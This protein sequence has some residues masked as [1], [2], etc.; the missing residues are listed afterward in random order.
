MARTD[1]QGHNDNPDY[2]EMFI[3]KACE[4]AVGM[5]CRALDFGCGT[6]RNVVNLVNNCA[7]DEVWGADISET[8]I[9]HCKHT[10]P[11]KLTGDAH[12]GFR[13]V[14]GNGVEAFE[15]WY[16]NYV[17]STIV[18]QHICV[19]EIRFEIL[20][21][22]FRVLDYDGL[23]V[24]QMGYGSKHPNSRGYYENF[25]DAKATNS[26]CDCR[27]EHPNQLVGELAIIGFKEIEVEIR[28]AWDDAHDK[29]IYVTARKP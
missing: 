2:W 14:S 19:H 21:D 11:A 18:L 22:I 10:V 13:T 24:F 20:E 27:V 23:F 26:K 5:P 8:N 1:H 3:D 7:F 12:V 9:A 15:S 17:M 28:D 25:Y 6:G 4:E 29:W 16:F